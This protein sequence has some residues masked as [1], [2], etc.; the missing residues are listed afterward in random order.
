MTEGRD[1]D[2]GVG[3][4]P[5]CVGRPESTRVTVTHVYLQTPTTPVVLF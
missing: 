2:V 5:Q 1:C 3:A 4:G